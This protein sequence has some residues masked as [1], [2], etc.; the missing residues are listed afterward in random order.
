M[1]NLFKSKFIVLSLIIS[2]I[3]SALLAFLSPINYWISS[4]VTMLILFPCIL[5]LYKGWIWAGGQKKLGLIII[6]AFILRLGLGITLNL[7][8]P[9]H[10]YDQEIHNSGYFFK[11][12]FERDMQAWEFATSEEPIWTSFHEQLY[13]DQYGGML[14]LS[15]IIYRYLSPDAHRSY[16]LLILAA[17]TS[18]IGIPFFWK[19]IKERWSLK[20]AYAS[21]WIMALYPDA[22]FYGSGQLR[23]PFLVGM[24]GIASWA[25]LTW[26]NHQ[27]SKFYALT[28]SIAGMLL[29]SSKIAILLIGFLL[30]WFLIDRFLPKYQGN[31]LYLWI[32]FSVFAVLLL[33]VSWG[34]LTDAA[35]FDTVTTFEK[36]GWV[37]KVI[38]EVGEE[39]T[40]PFIMGYGLAQPILPAAIA[41]TTIPIMRMIA[42][43]RAAGW[44]I[45]APFLVYGILT[46]WKA[47]DKHKRNLLIWLAAFSLFWLMISSGRAGGDQWDN[48]RYRSIFIPWLGFLASWATI[49]AIETRDFWLLRLILIEAIFVGFFTNWYFSRYFLWWRRL[50]FWTNVIWIV[51]LSAIVLSSGILWDLGKFLIGRKKSND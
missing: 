49:K 43:P 42:I 12:A 22:L 20:L 48:P 18:A 36:S 51:S 8:L 35:H 23:E 45:L 11:D 26:S 7:T 30:V 29:F 4:L 28:A 41:E 31:Q 9:E 37:N 44:Y 32:G 19:G 33:L 2:A 15:A 39:W 16:L 47:E 50:P 6:L 14:T 46:T 1:K 10:G 5:A 25:I 27:R 40:Y 17:F 34:W 24:L 21:V 13:T 38:K 3:L